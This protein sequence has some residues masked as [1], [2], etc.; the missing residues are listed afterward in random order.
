MA[1]SPDIVDRFGESHATQCQRLK[2]CVSVVQRGLLTLTV[3]VNQLSSR[4]ST[5]F[6]IQVAWYHDGIRE[7][8]ELTQVGLTSGQVLFS[9]ERRA[10][11][12]FEVL[13]NGVHMEVS[14]FFV[15]VEVSAS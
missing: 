12:L 13:L 10:Q 8:L 14:P 2:N 4:N 9:T 1:K 6:D 5:D 11:Y 7:E 15:T 3:I